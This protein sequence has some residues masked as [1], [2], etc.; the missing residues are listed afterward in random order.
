[1]APPVAKPNLTKP[2]AIIGRT[3][4]QDII[5]KTHRL[6]VECEN[7]PIL[8]FPALYRSAYGEILDAVELG[9]D[10][11]IVGL[12]N[13]L[14]NMFSLRVVRGRIVCSLSQFH[15]KRRPRGTSTL[16]LVDKA[17]ATRPLNKSRCCF[18]Q[19]IL[20]KETGLFNPDNIFWRDLAYREYLEARRIIVPFSPLEHAAAKD[21]ER[22]QFQALKIHRFL[23]DRTEGI[24]L[25]D[26]ASLRVDKVLF[27]VTSIEDMVHQYP[28]IFYVEGRKDHEL[29]VF[30]GK[31]TNHMSRHV[32]LISRLGGDWGMPAFYSYAAVQSGIYQMSIIL[33]REAGNEGLRLCVWKQAIVNNFVIPEERRFVRKIMSSDP[34]S[35]F[36]ALEAYNMIQIRPHPD[37]LNDL[38]LFLPTGKNNYPEAYEIT[39]EYLNLRQDAED[40][41]KRRT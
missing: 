5:S 41:E 25:S 12:F 31:T 16:D 23:K 34:I 9:F 2:K 35:F 4:P 29:L 26:L 19:Y 20:N 36:L 32:D 39:L 13:A 17:I 11:G 27:N 33:I 10:E 21:P 22:V 3:L 8:V 15:L 18:A 7:I 6:L 40:E 14:P 28:E 30:D 38:R 1:M 37:S 24:N